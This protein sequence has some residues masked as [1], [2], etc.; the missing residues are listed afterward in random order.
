MS[1]D[2]KFIVNGL[3]KIL[4]KNYTLLSLKALNGDDLLQVRIKIIRQSPSSIFT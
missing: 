4:K 3:N 1:E 2:L